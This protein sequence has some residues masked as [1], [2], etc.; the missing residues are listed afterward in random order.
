MTTINQS[1][2]SCAGPT[3]TVTDEASHTTT[4]CSDGLG[5]LKSVIDAAGNST[6]Y[7][8]NLLDDLTQVTMGSQFRAFEYTTTGRLKKACNPESSPTTCVSPLGPTGVDI[9]HYDANGNLLSWINPHGTTVTYANSYDG[10]NRQIV[11]ALGR[12][13]RQSIRM[14][15]LRIS[16]ERCFR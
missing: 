4:Y 1:P 10:L 6:S 14:M 2:G 7:S 11:K 5:R 13:R 15:R 8:Y 3:S 12:H 16:K 9:Y